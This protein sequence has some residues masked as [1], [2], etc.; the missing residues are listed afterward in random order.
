MSNANPSSQGHPPPDWQQN[1]TLHHD[2]HYPTSFTPLP[3]GY[4]WV[5]IL[6]TNTNSSKWEQKLYE[7]PSNYNC[8]WCSRNIVGL[9]YSPQN[10]RGCDICSNCFPHL[11]NR[12]AIFEITGHKSDFCPNQDLFVSRKEKEMKMGQNVETVIDLCSELSTITTPPEYMERL[13]LRLLEKADTIIDKLHTMDSKFETKIADLRK[14]LLV[15]P[16]HVTNEDP[17]T[18]V[19]NV[20]HNESADVTVSMNSETRPFPSCGSLPCKDVLTTSSFDEK[21]SDSASG[22]HENM[23]TKDKLAIA[24]D[25][26]QRK[27]NC[28][29]EG[30]DSFEKPSSSVSLSRD[31]RKK[32]DCNPFTNHHEK[33]I[34]Q[35]D[36][37]YRIGIDCDDQSFNSKVKDKIRYLGGIENEQNFG[38]SLEDKFEDISLKFWD[39]DAKKLE[40]KFSFS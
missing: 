14:E 39:D 18:T 28:D 7:F 20:L 17:T 30:T 36:T 6:D 16:P 2:I 1:F 27:Q 38:I 15:S 21:V 9:R 26:K 37:D 29:D 22:P 5:Y 10:H 12:G 23:Q 24:F 31:K 34:S 40:E 13:L 19:K 35:G 32:T 8:Y 11:R 3:K 33:N 25:R 4:H